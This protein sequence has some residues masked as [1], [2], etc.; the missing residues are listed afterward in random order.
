MLP[1]VDDLTL[2]EK[3][4][5]LGGASTWRTHPVERV[6]LP[7]VKM[8][9]GPNG[10]RGPQPSGGSMTVGQVC[11]RT[12]VFAYRDTL[13]PDAAKLMRENTSTQTRKM[14]PTSAATGSTLRC[15]APTSM[16]VT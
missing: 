10:V 14:A 1:E 16:R 12:V 9:D 11:N 8:S 4:R 3:C 6:G 13:L 15:S 5:L 7:A 2:E